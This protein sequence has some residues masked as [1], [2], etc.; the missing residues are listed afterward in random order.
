M[1]AEPHSAPPAQSLRKAPTTAVSPL[2]ETEMPRA[3]EDAE[4]IVYLGESAGANE[5]RTYLRHMR[6]VKN[7]YHSSQVPALTLAEIETFLEQNGLF[8]CASSSGERS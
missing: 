4:L 7:Q 5:E 3:Y 8:D 2:T 6:P 1:A